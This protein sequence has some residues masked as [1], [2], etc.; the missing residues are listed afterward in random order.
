M[1]ALTDLQATRELALLA[2]VG[3]S[4]DYRSLDRMGP[5]MHG[6]GPSLF[7]DTI[8]AGARKVHLRLRITP[9]GSSG[10]RGPEL[11][12]PSACCLLRPPCS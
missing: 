11:A 3:V 5:S 2:E 8:L 9:S 1:V 6:Q 4:A 7:A 10:P 12:R